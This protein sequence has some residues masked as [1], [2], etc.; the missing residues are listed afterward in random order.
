MSCHGGDGSGVVERSRRFSAVR[1]ARF[2][3][4]DSHLLLF[5]FVLWQMSLGVDA[6]AQYCCDIMTF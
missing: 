6:A 4:F 2:R 1:I 5:P 3:R